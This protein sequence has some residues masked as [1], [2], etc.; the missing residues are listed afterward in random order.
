MCLDSKGKISSD[1][2]PRS[3]RTY[4]DEPSC[5]GTIYYCREDESEQSAPFE[6]LLVVR[7]SVFDVGF[8]ETTGALRN[9]GRIRELE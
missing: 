9:L 5:T 3:S 2:P 7:Y 1:T 4:C 6:F 8:G